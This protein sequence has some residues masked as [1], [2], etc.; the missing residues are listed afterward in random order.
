MHVPE[1]W[2]SAGLSNSG[3]PVVV[4]QM[5]P[6]SPDI[7]GTLKTVLKSCTLTSGEGV[8]E[9]MVQFFG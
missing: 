3:H 6:Q 9:V 8:Q 7:F 4:Q 5:T 2:H 1:V